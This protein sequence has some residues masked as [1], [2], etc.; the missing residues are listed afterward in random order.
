M[1]TMKALPMLDHVMLWVAR[2]FAGLAFLLYAIWLLNSFGPQRGPIYNSLTEDL[3]VASGFLLWIIGSFQLCSKVVRFC[4]GLCSS[5]CIIWL[6]YVAVKQ[7]IAFSHITASV[8]HF[9][10]VFLFV[11]GIPIMVF[12]SMLW[13]SLR[14][15]QNTKSSDSYSFPHHPLP[16]SS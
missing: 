15:P 7:L 13:V 5:L 3:L 12:G 1:T 6:L 10:S 4:L 2:V 9:I 8:S 14:P 11:P 16:Q